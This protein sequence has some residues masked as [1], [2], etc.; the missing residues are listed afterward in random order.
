MVP[1]T[2]T[3]SDKHGDAQCIYTQQE[4][5]KAE[6][7]PFWLPRIHS[8]LPY[9]NFSW[10]SNLFEEEKTCRYCQHTITTVWETFPCKIA[11]ITGSKR[12]SLARKCGV[13]NL[14]KQQLAHYNKTEL[15]L[16]IKYSSYGCNVCTSLTLCIIPCFEIFHSN[17][18]FRQVALNYRLD[19]L[20]LC[21]V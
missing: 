16:P 13:F 5:W 4:I 11:S 14:T 15:E 17:V 1:E 12:K 20:P 6:S 9:H 7:L 3:A 21:N 10:N 8:K 18:N 2:D 19:V